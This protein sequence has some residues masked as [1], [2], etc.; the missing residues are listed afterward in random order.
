MTVLDRWQGIVVWTANILNFTNFVRYYFTLVNS[1]NYTLRWACLSSFL[2]RWL[3][4]LSGTCSNNNKYAFGLCRTQSLSRCSAENWKKS[5]KNII[6]KYFIIYWLTPV[7]WIIGNLK[8]LVSNSPNGDNL[9]PGIHQY[10]NMTFFLDVNF[11]SLK[12]LR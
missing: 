2:L 10:L 4:T 11:L 8:A 5:E 6:V 3:W 12:K 1:Q 7:F 9:F